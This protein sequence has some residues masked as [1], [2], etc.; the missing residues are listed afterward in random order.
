MLKKSLAVASAVP[1]LALA[2]AVTPATASSP[3]TSRVEVMPTLHKVKP[4][5]DR[6]SRGVNNLTYH[7]GQ[8]ETTPSV[9]LDFWGTWW[10]TTTTTGSDGSY[11]FTNTQA[12]TYVTNF[13]TNV[14]GSSWA[15]TDTQYCQGVA[16][17]TVNCGSSGAHV[18]NST[19]QLKSSM[20]DST[21]SV[22]TSP[23]QSQIAAEAAYAAAQ[24]GISSTS[25]A[26]ATVIVLTP[27]N[28]S[29][30][31]FATSW[32]AWHSVTTY[33]GHNLPY[34]Y[35]PY[36]PSAGTSCGVNFVNQPDAFGHGYFD[37]FSVVGG[38][39]YAE[40]ATDPVTSTGGYAWYDR[41]GNENGDK[42]AWSPGSAN[43]SL[44]GNNYAVQPL[45]SNQISGCAL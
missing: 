23:S 11:S 18:T 19:G 21:N 30:S 12:K 16:T 14:G 15:G 34:A 3:R 8:V 27:A 7:G 25:Q 35:L 41:G 36:Q 26:G 45:W 6:F 5:Q 40:A 13:Y 39:E 29:M 2:L 32:C 31:G 42:C 22:P 44:G 28:N 43:I 10:N 38:H 1:L 9:Y 33:S 4:G 17:G 20:V 24:F 37:G